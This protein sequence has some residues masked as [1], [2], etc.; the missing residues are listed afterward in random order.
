MQRF[1]KYK[2]VRPTTFDQVNDRHLPG[3]RLLSGVDEFLQLVGVKEQAT[4]DAN[5]MKFALAN[6]CPH[7]VWAQRQCASD[8]R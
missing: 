1:H 2:Q 3:S 5:G 8:F 4:A 6:K 7:C